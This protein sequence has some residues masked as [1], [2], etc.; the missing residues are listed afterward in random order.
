MDKSDWPQTMEAARELGI[1][2]IDDHGQQLMYDDAA[3]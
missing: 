3:Q 2:W 1:P